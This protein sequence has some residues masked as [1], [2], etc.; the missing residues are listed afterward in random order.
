MGDKKHTLLPY[1][2]KI[3]G[4]SRQFNR[5]YM[6]QYMKLYWII[7]LLGTLH[8]KIKQSGNGVSTNSV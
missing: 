7:R 1:Q 5:N 4:H 3:I 8:L 6:Y 2:Q